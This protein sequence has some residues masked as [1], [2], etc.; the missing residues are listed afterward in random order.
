MKVRMLEQVTG[1]RNGVAWPAPGG[2][3]D[4]PDGEARKLLEQGRAEPVDTA[5][6]RGRD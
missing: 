1:T 3:V 6:K 2:V 4:L 5:K